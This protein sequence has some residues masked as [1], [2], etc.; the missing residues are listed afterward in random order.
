MQHVNQGRLLVALVLGVGVTLSTV[1]AAQGNSDRNIGPIKW[2]APETMSKSELADAMASHAGLS[3][4][5]AKKALDG[6]INATSSALSTEIE[7]PLYCWGASSTR[8]HFDDGVPDYLDPDDDGDGVP[9]FHVQDDDDYDFRN[10]DFFDPDGDGDGWPTLAGFGVFSVVSGGIGTSG[11]PLPNEI[12]F[13]AGPAFAAAPDNPLSQESGWQEAPDLGRAIPPTIHGLEVTAP[14]RNDGRDRILVFGNLGDR[15]SFQAGDEVCVFDDREALARATVAGVLIEAQRGRFEVVA[16]TESGGVNIGLVLTGIDARDVQRGLVVA[17]CPVERPVRCEDPTPGF[18]DDDL[19]A[20]IVRETRLPVRTATAALVA[21]YTV[22]TDVVNSGGIVDL[23][24]FGRFEAETVIT[25]TIT[26][27]RRPPLLVIDVWEH[28]VSM[29]G[30]SQGEVDLVSRQVEQL[31]KRT[32]RTGRNPQTGKEIKIA[33][34]NNVRFKAGA[35]LSKS[36][37]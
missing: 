6:F 22:V 13:H 20:G 37:N 15:A 18:D 21:L 14:A 29:T 28:S 8:S 24:G 5:D 34:K 3:K 10:P 31:A 27:T 4:A 26:E 1:A 35:E 23:E 2:M 17:P 7:R 11:C 19:I 32:A 30:A 12:V 33:A 16:S 25:A 9:G 36:V